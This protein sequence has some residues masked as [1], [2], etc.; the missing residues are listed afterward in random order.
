VI[1][2]VLR[3]LKPIIR[4]ITNELLCVILRENGY[5]MDN[6]GFFQDKSVK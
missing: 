2:A 5:K 4:S 1:L 3:L 6:V